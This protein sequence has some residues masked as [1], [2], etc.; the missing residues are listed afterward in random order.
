[1]S[2]EVIAVLTFKSREHI[3]SVGGTCS[4]TLKRA[5]AR[6]FPLVV[7]ARNANSRKAE[8]PEAHATGFLVGRIRDVVPSPEIPGRW[9]IAFSEYAEIDVPGAWKGWRNPVRYSTLEELGID[10]AE[11]AF[12]P[13]PVP[14]IAP[15]LAAEDTADEEAEEAPFR[16]TLAQAKQG[17]ANTFNVSPEAVEI[18]IRA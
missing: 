3:L 14:D 2:T 8:G 18:T 1:M 4:W 13:M 6:Q 12:K 16:L 7:C 15:E 17:L 10:P 11:L 5:H 9:L